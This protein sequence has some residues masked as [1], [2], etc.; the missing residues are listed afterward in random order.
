MVSIRKKIYQYIYVHYKTGYPARY[1]DKSLL[2]Y[3][4]RKNTLGSEENDKISKKHAFF[5]K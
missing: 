4:Y 5:H 3:C 2:E 1:F